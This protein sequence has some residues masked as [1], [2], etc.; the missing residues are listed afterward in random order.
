MDKRARARIDRV[1]Q[2][3]K[4]AGAAKTKAADATRRVCVALVGDGYSHR[5]IGKLLGI[6]GVAVHKIVRRG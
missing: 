3:R 2:L 6:S 4:Q 5:D 1:L